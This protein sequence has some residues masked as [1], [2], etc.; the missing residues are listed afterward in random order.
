MRTRTHRPTPARRWVAAGLLTALAG[1]TA[2][3]GPGSGD[4]SGGS[5]AEPMAADSGMGSSRRPAG[6]NA[7]VAADAAVP[8]RSLVATRS[9]VMTGQLALTAPDLA[10]VRRQIGELLRAAGGSVDRERSFDDDAGRPERVTLVLRI[11]VRRFDATRHAIE[12]LGKRT[13]STS[14]TKDVTT[15]VIDVAE[16]V[17]TLQNSLDRLQRFQR[18]AQDASTL[19]RFEDQITRRQSELQSLEAQQSYLADQTSKSTLTVQLSTPETYVAPP[20]AL[21]EAGFLSGLRGGWQAL[22]GFG[23]VVLTVLGAALPFVV[24]LGLVGVP[25]WVLLRG[26]RRRSRTPAPDSP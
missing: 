24:A 2:C 3:T 13:S 25:A 12:R 15:Q 11:P 5:T 4:E 21:D 7:G 16:R 14:T 19:I 22:L 20:G 18:S 26:L 8:T 17:Q 23:I 6:R 1:L 10:Q 9:V